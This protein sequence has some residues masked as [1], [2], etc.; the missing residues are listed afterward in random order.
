MS[1]AERPRPRP[2]PTPSS[3][4]DTAPSPA[5]DGGPVARPDGK[6]RP[7]PGGAGGPRDRA[8]KPR[9]SPRGPEFESV[10]EPVPEPRPVVTPDTTQLD[11]Q[12]EGGSGQPAR[13]Q[14]RSGGLAGLRQRITPLAR[15]TAARAGGGGSAAARRPGL[16][17]PVLTRP[18]Q[19]Y[20]LVVV[21]ATLVSLLLL[22]TVGFSYEQGR[23]YGFP[24]LLV[25]SPWW[26]L[27]FLIDPSGWPGL[28]PLLV[29]LVGALVNAVLINHFTRRAAVAPPTRN[30]EGRDS[31]VH[32]S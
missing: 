20:L 21:A 7:S 32:H 18:T 9:P 15:P 14:R 13:Q 5:A 31:F 29:L 11:A 16:R 28:T 17:A 10:P 24:V 19:I 25:T 2:T 26:L 3:A 4:A 22:A 30:L 12:R 6:R 1:P 8:T 23:A 27:F